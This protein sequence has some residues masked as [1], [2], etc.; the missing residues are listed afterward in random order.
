MAYSVPSPDPTYT[1]S[2]DPS[3]FVADG[4]DVAMLHCALCTDDALPCAGAVSCCVAAAGSGVTADESPNGATGAPPH[5]A[6]IPAATSRA[7]I[8]C[9]SFGRYICHLVQ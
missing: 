2:G 7:S 9:K 5:A 4:W 3:L 8:E 6:S 1:T